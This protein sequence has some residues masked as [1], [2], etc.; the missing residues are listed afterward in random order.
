MQ[1][2]FDL[3]F[4]SAVRDNLSNTNSIKATLA[5]SG[6]QISLAWSQCFFRFVGINDRKIQGSMASVILNN[7]C[8][9]N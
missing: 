9:N 5:K 8:G 6:S 1:D 3:L 2:A 7:K 4:S